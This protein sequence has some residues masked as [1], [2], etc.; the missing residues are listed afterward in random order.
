MFNDLK[1][2]ESLMEK[3]SHCA[4]CEATCPVY[5]AELVETSV[6]RS[7][8]TVIKEA[9]VNKNLPVSKKVRQIIDDCLLCSNCHQTC[10]ANV[11]VDE[12]VVAARHQLYKGKRMN[13]AKRM[14]LKQVMENRGLKGLLKKAD[15][16]AKTVG[17]SP[18]ELPPFP[19]RPFDAIYSGTLAPE[20][21]K[22]ARVVY[23]VGCAT[24]A[25]YPDTGIAVIKV[26][27]KN[28]IEVVLPEG[29]VCCGLPAISEG[30]IETARVMMEQNITVLANIE[31]D[32]IVTDCT[33]CGLTFSKK[34]A[35]VIA[36]DN[37]LF[38][39]SRDVAA[40][41]WEVTDYLNEIGLSVAPGKLDT[42]YTYHVPCH[43]NWTETVNDA[44]RRILERVAGAELK[45]ME[46]P[47]KCCG[48]AGAHF[49]EHRALSEKIRTPKIKDI[50]QSGADLVVTQCPS[51]R[52][53]LGAALKESMKVEHPMMVLAR[54]YGYE[55]R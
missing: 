34:M 31:A 28:G 3:C 37:P 7:R 19:A 38:E 16:V 39:K 15:S 47:E 46:D 21:K 22:R 52:T 8:M 54:A 1:Q 32:A 11:P 49:I 43:G 53:Y 13:M 20:G 48:A 4:F 6:A 41:M 18:R 14:L 23:F 5:L 9:L 51:C 2:Y 27:T 33:S 12:I 35:K 55:R 50:A 36:G 42:R 29:L 25:F 24:N 40:K 44:P 10:P 17:I 45:E 26:L 30:D